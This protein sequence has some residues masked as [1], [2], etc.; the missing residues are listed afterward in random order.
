M[1]TYFHFWFE[2]IFTKSLYSEKKTDYTLPSKLRTYFFR[3]FLYYLEKFSHQNSENLVVRLLTITVSFVMSWKPSSYFAQTI[4]VV[5]IIVHQ[6]LVRA[7]GNV[8]LFCGLWAVMRYRGYEA[9]SGG[10]RPEKVA[11]GL[12]SEQLQ[13]ER[14]LAI[15]EKY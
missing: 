14:H 12:H 4:V 8:G 15:S 10:V 13:C 2:K 5:V 3:F 1:K 6:G 7:V 9:I 11:V